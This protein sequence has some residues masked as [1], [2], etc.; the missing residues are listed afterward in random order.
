ME[1]FKRAAAE[2]VESGMVVGLGTGSTAAWVV[3]SIGRLLFRGKL[4]CIKGVPTSERTAAFAREVGLPLTSLSAHTPDVVLDGADEIGPG[5]VLIKG[6]GG[7]LLREKI[8]ASA[9][10][11]L[12]VV[13]DS[14]KVVEELGR[15]PLPAEVEP[16]GWEATLKAL[17]SLGCEARLR[18]A[19]GRLCI[20]DGGHYVIDCLFGSIPAPDLLEIEI[21]R[22]PGAIETGLFVGLAQTAVIGR[23]T[24]VEVRDPHTSQRAAPKRPLTTTPA[25]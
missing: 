12:V 20:T 16:F 10:E 11:G 13:A 1:E 3:R 4:R 7:T 17:L 25:R 21:K 15:G 18:T 24:G 23:G 9:A 2:Y 14:S 5:L 19:K 8:V 6:R 22:I